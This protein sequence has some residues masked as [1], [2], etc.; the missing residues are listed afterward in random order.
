[1]WI[2]HIYKTQESYG[3]RRPCLVSSQSWRHLF[4]LPFVTLIPQAAGAHF[5]PGNSPTNPVGI[6]SMN[7]NFQQVPL[8]LEFIHLLDTVHE[9]YSSVKCLF[10]WKPSAES[11]DKLSSWIAFISQTP[12]VKIQCTI[13]LPWSV[14]KLS[15]YL[16]VKTF[17]K[18]SQWLRR[19]VPVESVVYII[20]STEMK[21]LECI[22]CLHFIS[23][24]EDY[25]MWKPRVLWFTQMWR[26]LCFDFFSLII[27]ILHIHA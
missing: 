9:L 20:H 7:C 2:F 19:P 25:S 8:L 3:L 23:P 26:Y 4:I 11:Y 15:N 27:I 17:C 10:F 6:Q 22:Y 21:F 1:M 18:L 5:I 13:W 14:S 16:S 12:F 24:G